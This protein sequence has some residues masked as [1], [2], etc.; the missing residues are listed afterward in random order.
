MKWS[1]TLRQMNLS[2]EDIIS[3]LWRLFTINGFLTTVGPF[4]S[5]HEKL[6]L[7]YLCVIPCVNRLVWQDPSPCKSFHMLKS[8]HIAQFFSWTLLF[9]N[10]VRFTEFLNNIWPKRN[11]VVCF[12]RETKEQNSISREGSAV[13]LCVQANRGRQHVVFKGTVQRK[14]TGV[15]RDIDWKVFLSHWT[16]DIFF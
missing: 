12:H 5:F 7:L 11:E 2:S 3:Y 8:F 1:P 15:A 13:V 9:L 16:A 10:F 14:L 4:T 6:A